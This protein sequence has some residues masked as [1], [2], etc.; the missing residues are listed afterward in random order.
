[1]KR[2]AAAVCRIEA[3]G[4]RLRAPSILSARIRSPLLLKT[5]LLQPG[6]AVKLGWVNEFSIAPVPARFNDSGDE[7]LVKAEQSGVDDGQEL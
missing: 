1:M 6:M 5:T 4:L 2:L 7:S 3:K